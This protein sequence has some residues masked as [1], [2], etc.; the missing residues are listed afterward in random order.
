MPTE[1]SQPLLASHWV[2]SAC[3]FQESDL[4]CAKL[5]IKSMHSACLDHQE[6]HPTIFDFYPYIFMSLLWRRQFLLMPHSPRL[7][8]PGNLLETPQL[9]SVFSAGLKSC[10]KMGWAMI[11]AGSNKKNPRGISLS[12]TVDTSIDTTHIKS[13]SKLKKKKVFPWH[14][15]F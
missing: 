8:S 5:P 11:S 7:F 15:G 6:L 1:H 2:V 13:C 3:H 9:F 10:V 12:F 4:S 14:Q